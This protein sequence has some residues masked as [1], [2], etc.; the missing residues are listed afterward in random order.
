[1][2]T[3]KQRQALKALAHHKDPVILVGKKGV[4]EP[5]VEETRHALLA[6]ELI[7]VKFHEGV[8]DDAA[9]HLA[10]ESGSEVVFVQGKIVTLFAP[11]PD[12]PRIKLPA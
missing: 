4:T 3:S 9:A 1:M 5:L 6:H 7:K 8:D 12:K 11:H 2:L 10:T